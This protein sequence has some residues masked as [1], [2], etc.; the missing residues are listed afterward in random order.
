MA[1]KKKTLEDAV[2]EREAVTH[3]LEPAEFNAQD[4]VKSG[5]L[6]LTDRE[7]RLLEKAQFLGELSAA[8]YQLAQNARKE[9]LAKIDPEGKLVA[10][11]K[12]MQ[13][14]V[15]EVQTAKQKYIA[16]VANIEARAGIKLQEY[17]WD[18]Q[19][20]ILRKLDE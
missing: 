13:R 19:T 6:A 7:M 3:V 10:L 20:G 14:F 15:S 4:P 17:S 16:A 8:K 12:D 18:E 11:E 9:L 2:A 1:R 5:V